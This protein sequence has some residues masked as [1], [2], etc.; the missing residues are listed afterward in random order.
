[1]IQA[2]LQSQLVGTQDVAALIESR[3]YPHKLP[4][5]VAFPAITYSLD[6]DSL[7]PLL[8]GSVSSLREALALVDCWAKTYIEAVVV[9]DTV[10]ET[11]LGVVAAGGEMGDTDPVQ[12]VD[13][14]RQERRFELF[15]D[16]TLLYR[17][18]LQF[19]IAYYP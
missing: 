14:V 1:M 16:D 17:V 8:D 7:T 15:E 19:A 12:I 9:A 2:A 10:V 5:G 13:S 3:V 6:Q 18:S 4:Q 11:L